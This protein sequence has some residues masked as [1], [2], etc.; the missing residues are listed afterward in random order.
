M[1]EFHK[2][3]PTIS[4][5]ANIIGKGLLNI[6][7]FTVIE[8]YVLLDTSQKKSSSISIG[9]RCKIKQGAI[10]RTYD[11][12]IEIGD[13]V[14]IGEFTVIAGHGK[15]TIGNCTLLAAQCYLTAADH[16]YIND[17]MTRFQGE[18]AG[19]ISIGNNVWI[20]ANVKVLDGVKIGDGSIIGA[21]S[22][23]TKSLPPNSICYGIPCKAIKKRELPLEYKK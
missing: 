5:K 13:R 18:R 11:G 4:K 9:L 15:I 16:I 17:E 23:V 12:S 7:S 19:G 14:S 20:G 21:A 1:K 3:M 6:K 22:L 8:D 10:L 2:F